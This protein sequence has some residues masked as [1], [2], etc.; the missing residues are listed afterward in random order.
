MNKVTISNPNPYT[1]KNTEKPMVAYVVTGTP[2]AVEAYRQYQKS[3]NVE[4]SD[5]NGNPLAHFNAPTAVKYGES[6]ELIQGTSKSGEEIWYMDNNEQKEL[7]KLVAG[8]DE[9]TKAIYA[10]QKLEEL[11]AFARTLASNR[12]K[13]IAKLQ[14]QGTPKQTGLTDM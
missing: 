11:K 3:Q 12:A 13:N 10:A 5:E 14:A 7:E 9:T 8:A 1:S 4:S 2:E 6:A